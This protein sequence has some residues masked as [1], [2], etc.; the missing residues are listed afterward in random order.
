MLSIIR[1]KT[2]IKCL[3]EMKERQISDIEQIKESMANHASHNCTTLENLPT[4]RF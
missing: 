4:M 1:D 3:T 2:A